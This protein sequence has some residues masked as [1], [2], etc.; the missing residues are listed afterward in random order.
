[1]PFFGGLNG[2]DFCP[3]DGDFLSEYEGNYSP[4]DYA[5]KRYK[6]RCRKCGASHLYWQQYPSGR[7]FIFEQSTQEPHKCREN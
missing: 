3:M 6:L 7:W 2:D 1:M 5:A 4:P